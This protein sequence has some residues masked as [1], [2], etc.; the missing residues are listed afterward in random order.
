MAM[1]IS[2][3]QS[4]PKLIKTRLRGIEMTVKDGQ[5]AYTLSVLD[6]LRNASDVIYSA[7]IA[8]GVNPLMIAGPI[9]R[10]MNKEVEPVARNSDHL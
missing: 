9:A 2:N 6:T 4:I 8:A 3:A 5:T 7:A 10:E 1:D